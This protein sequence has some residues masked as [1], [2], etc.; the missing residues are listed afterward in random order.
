MKGGRFS[1]G[2]AYVAFSR[3]KTLLGLHI[4]NFNAASI[5]TSTNVENEMSRLN[6]KLLQPVPELKCLSLPNNYVTLSVLNVRPI[7]TKQADILLDDCLKYATILCFCETW[8]IPRHQTPLVKT[9][10]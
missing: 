7:N 10:K 6:S 2:Q 4:V 5:K 9:I 1:A 8:L 3:V